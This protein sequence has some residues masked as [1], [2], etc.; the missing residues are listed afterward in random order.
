MPVSRYTPKD[1][2]ES[3][4][5][6]DED[7]ITSSMAAQLAL[8]ED[9][10]LDERTWRLKSGVDFGGRLQQYVDDHMHR[11]QRDPEAARAE[12]K[13]WRRFWA[14]K[15]GYQPDGRLTRKEYAYARDEDDIPRPPWYDDSISI[16]KNKPDMSRSIAE[17]L[18]SW[19]VCDPDKKDDENPLRHTPERVLGYWNK[20][21]AKGRMPTNPLTNGAMPPNPLA[22]AQALSVAVAKAATAVIQDPVPAI[23][24]PL[25]ERPRRPTRGGGSRGARG[26]H[27]GPAS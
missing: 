19:A 11:V 12:A 24:R 6:S 14:D 4:S 5:D 27:G 16:F 10:Q 23:T 9:P 18:H 20:Y 8:S 15:A 22:N 26:G 7:S 1:T 25:T 13:K 21:D 17:R 2:E 3:T